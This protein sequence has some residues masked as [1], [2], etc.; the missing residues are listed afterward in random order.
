MPSHRI[1]LTAGLTRDDFLKLVDQ[2]E[3]DVLL[4]TIPQVVRIEHP[5]LQDGMWFLRL[6]E[7]VVP[8]N[9]QRNDVDYQEVR[10]WRR[11]DRG[12]SYPEIPL[13]AKGNYE[14]TISSQIE[15]DEDSVTFEISLTNHGPRAWENTLAWLCFNHHAAQSYYPAQTHILTQRGWERTELKGTHYSFSVGGCELPWWERS[16][17]K[18]TRGI[19]ATCI[20]SDGEPYVVAVASPTALLLGQSSTWP[21][22]DIGIGFGN[23]RPGETVSRTGRIYFHKGTLDELA[24]RFK[25]EFAAA[26]NCETMVRE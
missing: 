9:A 26:S 15:S 5:V 8:M 21:C 7:L 1:R 24:E 23:P 16:G 22:T 20:E 10:N 6:P 25:S 4:G 14:G 3:N 2:P 19:I 13:S 11:N 18:T 17:Q 12:W